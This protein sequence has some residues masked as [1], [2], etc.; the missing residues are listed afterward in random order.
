MW[1]IVVVVCA[2]CRTERA[3]SHVSSDTAVRTATSHP[4]NTSCKPEAPI[5]IALA[6]RP[7]AAGRY[8]L[9]LTATPTRDVGALDVA[10]R[11]PPGATLDRPE[12]I[13]FGA[14]PVGMTRTVV[15]IA[16]ATS[17]T[18]DVSAIAR[19]PV[20]GGDR[21][22]ISMSRSATVTLGDPH[23]APVIRQYALPD[24]DAAR[25]VRP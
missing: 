22:P 21:A 20:D 14:T 18:T 12:R 5:A 24:G 3:T 16:T 23:P 10:F 17:R 11:L 2:A 19:V 6:S 1:L 15:A 4:A 9:T 8:E 7:L 13:A 25:E